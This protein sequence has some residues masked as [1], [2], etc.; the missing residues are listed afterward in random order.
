[1]ASSNS[2]HESEQTVLNKSFNPDTGLLQV[3][4]ME[5]DGVGSRQKSSGVVNAKIT[6]VG[7]AT[8]IGIS[9]PGTS[10]NTSKWQCKKIDSTDPDDILI[11]W[12]GDGSFNQPASDIAGLTYS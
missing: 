6:T 4:G 8:Y 12:A 7:D 2:I 10:V 9:A 1:M 5:T 11:T 3:E